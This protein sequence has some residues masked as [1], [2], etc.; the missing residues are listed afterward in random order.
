MSA[1]WTALMES[2]TKESLVDMVIELRAKVRELETREW[3][4]YPHE[5]MANHYRRVTELL[6]ANTKLVEER[7]AARIARNKAEDKLAALERMMDE[8]YGEDDSER[9]PH[10]NA[11]PILYGH[12]KIGTGLIL[13]GV[14]ELLIMPD[15]PLHQFLYNG[16]LPTVCDQK[17]EEMDI[18]P[19]RE[20]ELD[21]AI[22]YMLRQMDD[23]DRGI[24]S[25]D[26]FHDALSNLKAVRRGQLAATEAVARAA[27]YPL[28]KANTDK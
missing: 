21:K 10:P 23:A 3:L 5:E 6:D 19:V 11:V 16:P 2:E 20:R 9:E 22:D 15:P 14:S 8:E 26:T 27:N 13:S 12:T 28:D 24:G 7:R 17:V 18:K 25:S 1:L 4:P